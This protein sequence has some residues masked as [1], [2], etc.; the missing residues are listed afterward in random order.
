MDECSQDSH[1]C[2]VNADC[3][4]VAGSYNCVCRAGYEGDG[5]TCHI[6]KYH[7]SMLTRHH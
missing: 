5:K 4:N 2:S 7:T 6:G 1:N 3:S